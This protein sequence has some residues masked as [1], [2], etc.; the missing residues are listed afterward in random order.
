M[1]VQDV[2]RAL[3]A[4]RSRQP[5]GVSTVML[6]PFA[7]EVPLAATFFETTKLICRCVPTW[8]QKSGA[9]M[10]IFDSLSFAPTM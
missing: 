5:A 3:N 1:K 6:P 2:T 9:V 8:S 7:F 4:S 10:A